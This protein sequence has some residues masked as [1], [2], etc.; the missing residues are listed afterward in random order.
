MAYYTAPPPPY[1]SLD[2]KILFD[3]KLQQAVLESPETKRGL[4][5]SI[6]GLKDS[7]LRIDATFSRVAKSF[8]DLSRISDKNDSQ[9]LKGLSRRWND[10]HNVS[11]PR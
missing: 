8:R 5:L 6:D 11:K 7:T 3:D 4:R 2:I 9:K 10:L 1:Q